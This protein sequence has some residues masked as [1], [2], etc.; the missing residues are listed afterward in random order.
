MRS[1]RRSTPVTL[2]PVPGLWVGLIFGVFEAGML[3]SNAHYLG[4]ELLILTGLYN[5][6]RTYRKRPRRPR[7][8]SR[9]A[10]ETEH[11]PSLTRCRP[12]AAHVWRAIGPILA[13]L[14]FDHEQP[15]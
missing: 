1:V 3:G 12:W 10:P 14:Q 4:G 11:D 13:T 5:L 7:R 2:H 9:P 15:L 8:Q 6:A